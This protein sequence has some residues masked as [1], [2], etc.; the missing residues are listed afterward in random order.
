MTLHLSSTDLWVISLCALC[1]L[2]LR[3]W[4]QASQSAK[5]LPPGPARRF[6]IGNLLDLPKELDWLHWAKFKKLYGPIASIYVLGQNHIIV[7]KF[8]IAQELLEKRS[9][10]YSDRPK[11]MFGGEMIGWGETTSLLNYGAELKAQRRNIHQMMGTT[12][13]VSKFHYLE[14]IEAKR[15][16]KRVIE[17]PEELEQLIRVCVLSFYS[18]F[19]TEF[20][21]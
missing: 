21:D 9:A 19:S 4:A 18:R 16:I 14:D 5:L 20:I 2:L 6:L 8:E 3:N 15:F 10:I 17:N 11:I 12:K 1:F 7:N 13:S